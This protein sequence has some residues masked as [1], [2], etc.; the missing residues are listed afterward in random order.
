MYGSDGRLPT[1]IV[2]RMM[3]SG[4]VHA[5][6]FPPAQECLKLMVECTLHYN[7]RERKIEA[8][9]GRVLAY[10]SELAIQE[11]FGILVYNRTSYCTKEDALKLYQN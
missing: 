11:I 2:R 9:D 3:H 4:I 7:A 5:A 6:G 10:L 8:P 1:P